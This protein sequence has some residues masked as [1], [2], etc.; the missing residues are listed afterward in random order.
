MAELP[1]G[2]LSAID[3]QRT[4]GDPGFEG[5]FQV[6][7]TN[8]FPDSKEKLVLRKGEKLSGFYFKRYPIGRLPESMGYQGVYQHNG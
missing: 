6:L 5:K 1:S 8:W 4:L 2:F 3:L 7:V